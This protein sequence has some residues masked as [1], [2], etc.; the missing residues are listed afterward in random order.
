MAALNG[1]RDQLLA[2]TPTASPSPDDPA[3]GSASTA[4]H[5]PAAKPGYD[6]APTWD[7]YWSA[8][9]DPP[10]RPPP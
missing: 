9:N 4:P 6:H 7:D 1:A 8:W 2:G 10:R 3:W 5:R